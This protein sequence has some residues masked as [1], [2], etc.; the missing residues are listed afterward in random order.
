MSYSAETIE[1]VWNK[2]VRA[3]NPGRVQ[4]VE[5]GKDSCGA[6]IRRGDYGRLGLS[7]AWKIERI[8]SAA[9]GGGDELANLQPLQWE[10]TASKGDGE[11]GCVIKSQ[12]FTNVRV[13]KGNADTQK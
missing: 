5:W 13:G 3:A 4:N 8:K 10:N 12:G 6:W 2:A 1:A 9:E 7:Y 11:L